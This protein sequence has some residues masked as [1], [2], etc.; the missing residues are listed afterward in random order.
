MGKILLMIG[1]GWLV[2]GIGL[3]AAFVPFS[4]LLSDSFR[5]VIMKGANPLETAV[6]IWLSIAFAFG[7]FVLLTIGASRLLKQR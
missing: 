7:W 5:S 3:F 4:Y 1:I 2:A 6:A